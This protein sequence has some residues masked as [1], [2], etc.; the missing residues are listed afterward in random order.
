M[1]LISRVATNAGKTRVERKGREGSSHVGI[2]AEETTWRMS[3]LHEHFGN[4][5]TQPGVVYSCTVH[6]TAYMYYIKVSVHP[7][8]VL[9]NTLLYSIR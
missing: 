6:A 9:C 2:G 7:G 4:R 1:P 8:R 3:M 5:L